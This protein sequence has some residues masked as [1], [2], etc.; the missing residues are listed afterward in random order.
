MA[1]TKFQIVMVFQAGSWLADIFVKFSDIIL[2]SFGP[3][4]T[5]PVT[6]WMV[7]LLETS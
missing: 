3:N 5:L 2:G 4:G 6:S 1:L 7:T